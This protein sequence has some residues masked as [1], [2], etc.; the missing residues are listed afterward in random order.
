MSTVNKTTGYSP[1][2]LRFG[3]SPRVLP[4]LLN[5]PPNPSSDYISAREVINNLQNDVADARDN[6]I[7]AKISQA[8]FANPKTSQPH[9]YEIGQNV[10]LSTLH[11]RNE[12]KTKG[13]HR[14]A[15][16]MPRYDGPYQII[17]VH[18]D[19][20]TV[21]LEMPNAPNLFPTFH[22]S[23]VKPWFPN[24]DNKYPSRTLE[25]PGPIDVNGSE[26]F[27]VDSIIDHKKIGRGYRYLVHFKGYGPENDRWITGK[28]LE[29][30][31]ALEIYWKNNP[32]LFSLSD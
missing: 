1:F 19:A 4:P 12:Y 28:E 29:N 5:S 24:D 10:M 7:L 27:L 31:E 6:L 18:Q 3:R 13:Q 17:D 8:H 22:A 2:H 14:A 30:N 32:D 20:S 11:R 23:N 25:Q 9:L 16:F 15:K 21:T 26:E